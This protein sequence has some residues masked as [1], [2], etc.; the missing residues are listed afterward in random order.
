VYGVVLNPQFD[1]DE[2]AQP[3][4]PKLISVP[5]ICIPIYNTVPEVMPEIVPIVEVLGHTGLLNGAPNCVFVPP[6][7]NL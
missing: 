5:D 4:A 3:A 7:P 2:P 6:D 1:V